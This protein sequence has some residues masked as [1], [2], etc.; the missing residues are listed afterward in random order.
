MEVLYK[1]YKDLEF[2]DYIL[3]I[4]KVYPHNKGLIFFTDKYDIRLSEFLKNKNLRES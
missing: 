4:K 2:T 3:P 1:N